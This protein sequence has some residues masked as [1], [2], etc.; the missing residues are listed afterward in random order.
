MA[1][2]W[3]SVLQ[4]DT[5]SGYIKYIQASISVGMTRFKR[6]D[7]SKTFKKMIDQHALLT[8]ILNF[9]DVNDVKNGMERYSRLELKPLYRWLDDREKVE[10]A[11]EHTKRIMRGILM[12]M[13]V[14]IENAG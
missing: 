3:E 13:K 9:I 1:N 5:L 8:A 10:E 12:E 4:K 2:T 7:I 11:Y 14:V 6:P